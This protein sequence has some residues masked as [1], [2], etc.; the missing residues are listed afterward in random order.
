MRAQ[1]KDILQAVSGARWGFD[2]SH[3]APTHGVKVMIG[4][5]A[6]WTDT[7][8]HDHEAENIISGAAGVFEGL[9]DLEDASDT[10]SLSYF[11]GADVYLQNGG[12][13]TSMYARYSSDWAWFRQ[14]WLGIE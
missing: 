12:D 9:K 4:F 8:T 6:T 2:A 5:P 1:T 11:L 14:Y 10:I 3:P 7:A 13:D